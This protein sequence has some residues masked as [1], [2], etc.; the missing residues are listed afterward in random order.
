MLF[1]R[2]L[3]SRIEDTAALGTGGL[4]RLCEGRCTFFRDD[5]GGCAVEARLLALNAGDLVPV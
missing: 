2:K 1:Q 5:G 3:L 4:G